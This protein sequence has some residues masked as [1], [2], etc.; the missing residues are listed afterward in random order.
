MRVPVLFGRAELRIFRA[1]HRD[2]VLHVAKR[3]DVVHDRRAHVET[4]HRRKIRR[5]DARI[6]ALAFERF[7]QAGFFAADV[8]AGAAMD[9]N[10]HV[11]AGA[12]NIF[13]EKIFRARFFDG[14]FED[15]RAFG[16]FA[17]DVDVGGVHVERE[18]GDEHPLEQLMRILV[19][20]VA[21]LERA[22]L[23]F[24]R[25]ADQVDRFFLVRLDEAPFHAAGKTR[26]AAAAQSG[27]LDFVHDVGARHRDRLLQLLVAAVSQIAIDIGGLIFAPD[28]FENETA[29]E[30]MRGECAIGELRIAV[31]T[32]CSAA[33]SRTDTFSCNS[34]STMQTGAV[35]Q[36]ARHSTN[37]M[38]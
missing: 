4:E 27:N 11:E 37:S 8:G 32:E 19:N 31:V 9:V 21:I 30:R 20:D 38:L 28:V 10:L 15:F 25:I 7:D 5:L 3:L 22:R 1:A 33:R 2:D 18:A 23:G 34:S 24:V 29:L 26:A 13:P 12:E 16:K 35:P 14:A 6:G 36:L 17:A